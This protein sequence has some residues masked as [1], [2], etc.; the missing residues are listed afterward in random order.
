MREEK[1]NTNKIAKGLLATYKKQIITSQV[2]KVTVDQ[3]NLEFGFNLISIGTKE[4]KFLEKLR[5][6]SSEIKPWQLLISSSVTASR[7]FMLEAILR[8]KAL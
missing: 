5:A 1:I 4:I 2:I 3:I 6:K 8:E 7:I